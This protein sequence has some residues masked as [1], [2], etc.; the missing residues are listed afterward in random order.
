[1][2]R[3]RAR[4]SPARGFAALELAAAISI[5]ASLLI[6]A[7][8]VGLRTF[9]ASRLAEAVEGLERIGAGAV[10]YAAGGPGDGRAPKDAFPPAAPLTPPAPPRGAPAVDPPEL[11]AV[12]TWQALHFEPAPEGVAHSFAFAFEPAADGSRFVARAHGDLDGD[13][14]TSTFELR[15]TSDGSGHARV[16]PGLYVDS[17]VE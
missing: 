5:G 3:C 7:V 11:W 1:M 6:I 12:P 14:T 9:R 4:R 17:E 13:G 10:A 15:G 16:E 8:P 2:P